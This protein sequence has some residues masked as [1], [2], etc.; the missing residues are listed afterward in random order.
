MARPQRYPHRI[1]FWTTPQQY[2]ALQ[3]LTADQLTDTATQMRQALSCYL[4]SLGINT[5]PR[6]AQAMN[7]QEQTNHGI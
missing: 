1:E 2:D 6:P 7:G 4:R 3:L 5:A